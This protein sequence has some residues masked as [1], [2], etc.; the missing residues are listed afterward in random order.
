M[1]NQV[2]KRILPFSIGATLGVGAGIVCYNALTEGSTVSYLEVPV[3]SKKITA[4]QE[5]SVFAF[6]TDTHNF[7]L[8]KLE[9]I[10]LTL[11]QKNIDTL[12]LGGD[13]SESQ[14]H[15]EKTIR[16]LSQIPSRY[17]TFGVD[18]NH[19]KKILLYGLYKRYGITLLNNK[20]ILLPNGMY[21]SGTEDL[22]T[23]FPDVEAAT[24][25]APEDAFTLLITHNPDLSMLTSTKNIDLTVS[26]H[27]HGGQIT[28]F[29]KWA[30]LI[31]LVSFYG[32]RFR[33][34]WS[35]SKDKTPV[36]VSNGLGCGSVAPRIFA[37]PQVI[38]FRFQSN[39][40]RTR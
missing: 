9:E 16:I 18:G 23:G 1:N 4:D 29:R 34:G 37:Q 32:Q 5:G 39:K 6:I 30:P 12:L 28:L 36:Y 21:L 27:I 35:V 13:F 7:S 26:G 25:N 14:K 15:T 31:P 33:S 2:K 19:D 17:G 38:L 20:G 24:K 40:K 22:L 11:G 3:L 8:K 10:S